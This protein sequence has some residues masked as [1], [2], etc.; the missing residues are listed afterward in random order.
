[1]ANP[2]TPEEIAQIL[3]AFFETVG[4]RQ[5]IG[6]RYV[7]IFGR[8]NESSI[9][10]DNSGT[11]EPLTIV[12]YQGNSYTSR[13]FVPVGVEITNQEFWALTGNYNAQIE[14]YR[15]ETQAVKEQI[16]V[17]EEILPSSEF[18][19]QNTVKN[20][21][22][23]GCREITLLLREEIQEVANDVTSIENI[24]PSTSFDST[25]TVEAS[26]LD[27]ANVLPKQYFNSTDTVKKYIDDI[28][29]IV[30][31]NVQ[32]VFSG[33]ME[34]IS[35]TSFQLF[36]IPLTE[37]IEQISKRTL[38]SGFVSWHNTLEDY[39][40]PLLFVNGP[41]DGIEISNSNILLNETTGNYWTCFGV[42]NGQPSYIIQPPTATRK[43]AT[44]MIVEGWS[45]VAGGFACFIEDG[46]PTDL[47][48]YEDCYS[49]STYLTSRVQRAALGWDDE[50]WYIFVC[51]GRSPFN[52]GITK[53]EIIEIFQ[54]FDIPNGIDMDGGGSVQCYTNNPI[55][56]V[57]QV[58]DT[59]IN[60]IESAFTTRNVPFMISFGGLQNA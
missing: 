16:D 31:Q 44:E 28:K 46:Q 21:V 50:Y 42:K 33:V 10:W 45:F 37:P 23:D 39:P 26:I 30:P 34:N 59:N 1:M 9:E 54:H 24:I 47:T 36:K 2:F 58:S 5:Y 56:E 32:L 18:D 51:Q 29:K 22:D 48:A 43:T 60:N 7:P 38:G 25:N 17:V 13:Q 11:Y 8:K 52:T 15:R 35:P 53:D 49:Y 20:Y 4:T 12:L 55:F 19:A 6:A 57:T 14:M 41:L 40:H 3:E 27:I